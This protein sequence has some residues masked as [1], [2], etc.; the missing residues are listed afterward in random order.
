MTLPAKKLSKYQLPIG[1]N[2][3][4]GNQLA[5]SGEWFP[6]H[7]HILGPPGVGKTRLDL[8][9]FSSLIR[10]PNATVIL[11]NQK[12]EFFNMARD[13]VIANGQTSRLVTFD[14]GDCEVVCGYNPLR[15]NG[16]T[17]ATHAK[18]VRESIRAAWG[19]SSFDQTPQLARFLF[20]ALYIARELELTLAEA[21]GLLR[22][23]ST[24]RRTLL[25]R[26]TNPH[27]CEIVEY[28][29]ALPERRQEELTVSSTARLESFV[30]DPG[31]RR[32]LIQREHALDL[33]EILDQHKILLL[34]LEQY[35]PFRPDDCKLLARLILNDILAYVFER[36]KEKRTPVFLL[37]DE[38]HT[39]ATEDLCAM[40]ELGRELGF[41]VILS[42]QHPDQLLLEDGN[43][44]LRDAVMNNT[45]VKIIFGGLSVKNLR[46]L[47]EEVLI[48]QFDPWK[49]KDEIFS[50]ECEPVEETRTSSTTARSHSQGQATAHPESVSESEAETTT[51]GITASAAVGE[52]ESVSQASTKGKTKGKS[53][54]RS[55]G[56]TVTES[57]ADTQGESESWSE[58]EG[59]G[60][61]LSEI[62]TLSSASGSSGGSGYG[63]TTDEDGDITRSYHYESGRSDQ[64]GSSASSGRTTSA[65]SARAH[66]EGTM[67]AS[68]I[69][70][71]AAR[72]AS[73]SLG[74]QQ[75]ESESETKGKTK[76][77]SLEF[78]LGA[79]ANFGTTKGK[80]V[81]RG[82]T[83][84]ESEEWGESK[85]T[86][87]SPFHAYRK[88]RVPSSR[89]FL[90]QEE[91]LTLG[92]QRIKEQP[93]G[94]FVIKVP[95]KP[96]VF[97]RAPFVKE[98]R[99]T[100]RQLANARQRIFSQPYYS[101]VEEI[102]AEEQE[103]AKQ[104]TDGRQTVVE[105]DPEEVWVKDEK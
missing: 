11:G 93:R 38:A 54:E 25:P 53:S 4:T 1:S 100:T 23:G 56:K 28:F 44:R 50:L 27:L 18:Q 39:W 65:F 31:I 58:T 48:D 70:G 17:I 60:E 85:S 103:R 24:L 91:F 36:P 5:L 14:P 74:E 87:T 88:R 9:L 81:T 72:T 30:L 69:G 102:E 47:A 86:T 8:A 43:R 45:A 94:H 59:E 22:P 57:W 2:L 42:H 99:I 21:L 97:A 75:T 49:I 29:D 89:T 82:V 6:R 76:G 46:E 105:F 55:I 90:S 92:L 20:L 41:S 32:I 66:G 78:G 63:T 95:G 80:T 73:A 83:P 26:I 35:R 64:E 96:A 51:Y 10:I 61:S 12:G 19:Q 52:N 33:A 62:S 98:P 15:P 34:N 7:I 77:T 13:I 104:L 16:L 67:R 101:R 3:A 79:S 71:S 40:L 37:L 68:S 84:S